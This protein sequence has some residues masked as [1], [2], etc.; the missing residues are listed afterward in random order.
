MIVPIKM[1]CMCVIL[2]L[3][4]SMFQL[5]YAGR[6]IVLKLLPSHPM[7]D[8]VFF[9]FTLDSCGSNLVV[10]M[11]TSLL[12][13]H[14]ASKDYEWHFVVGDG[15]NHSRRGAGR[16]LW[17]K[18]GWFPKVGILIKKTICQTLNIML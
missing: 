1:A 16:I 6:Y 9:S 4:L 13:M 7:G 8:E 3:N 5:C 12:N 11:S 2:E 18:I 15:C 10:F 14:I 17:R